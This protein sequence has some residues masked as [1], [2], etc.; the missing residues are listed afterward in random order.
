MTVKIPTQT[1]P[2]MSPVF[3]PSSV[4]VKSASNTHLHLAGS[5]V[6]RGL[7]SFVMEKGLE[8]E[9]E[10]ERRRRRKEK[11]EESERGRK[12]RDL[13]QGQIERYHKFPILLSVSLSL[14][15]SLSLLSL[16]RFSPPTLSL[17]G[18]GWGGGSK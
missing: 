6:V 4:C 15:L 17:G 7:S 13:R 8:G 2:S 16:S 5:T 9:R 11:E 1:T 18:C 14:S 10:R 12:E 3:H